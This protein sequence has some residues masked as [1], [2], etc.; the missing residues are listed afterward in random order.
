MLTPRPPRRELVE[1]T[2][3]SWALEDMEPSESTLREL[4]AVVDGL[5]TLDDFHRNTQAMVDHG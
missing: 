2:M 3:A 5:H 4:Q 1:N